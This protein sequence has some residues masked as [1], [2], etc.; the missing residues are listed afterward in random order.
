VGTAVAAPSV[1]KG[2][3]REVWSRWLEEGRYR[4]LRELA[5]AVGL[6]AAQVSRVL[7]GLR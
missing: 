5:E 1:P 3:R 4:S 2:E 7:R 6:S